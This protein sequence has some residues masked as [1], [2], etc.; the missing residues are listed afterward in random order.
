MIGGRVHGTEAVR[1]R[2]QPLH[3]GRRIVIPEGWPQRQC[4]AIG[5]A[6]SGKVRL[7]AD[8]PIGE[9]ALLRSQWRLLD[10]EVEE[11]LQF[12]AV[13]GA[14]RKIGRGAR[15]AAGASRSANS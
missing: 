2:G 4:G 5:V 9:L 14:E 1:G 3:V 13:V 11:V 6:G 12:R 7:V 15:D 10:D 8:H